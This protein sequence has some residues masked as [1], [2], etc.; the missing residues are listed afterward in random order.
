MGLDNKEK[1]LFGILIILGILGISIGF[2]RIL[3]PF[4]NKDFFRNLVLKTKDNI[5]TQ[6]GVKNQLETFKNLEKRDSDK[7]GLPDL[8]EILTYNTSPYLKDTDSDGIDDKTEIENGTD[9]LCPEGKKCGFFT[10]NELKKNETL[11]EQKISENEKLLEN[12]KE[13][14]KRENL[15]NLSAKDLREMLKNQGV[16]EEFL[17]KIDD[18]T[19]EETWKE[20]IKK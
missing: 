17:N 2:Y 12:F 10:A 19:L 3:T 1:L 11:N 13:V 6:Q 4:I 9:P 8:E 14:L 20:I 7:D 5:R 16:S 15:E 18:K